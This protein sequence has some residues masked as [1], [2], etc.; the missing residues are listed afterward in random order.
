MPTF[1]LDDEGYTAPRAADFLSTIRDR[2]QAE[3]G[4]TIDWDA[5][6]V[7]GLLTAIMADQLG[8]LGEATQD[9]R[10]SMDPAS[11]RG[12]ALD[13]LAQ[14]VGVTRTPATYS[15]VT[16]A[17]TGVNGT[18]V[19]EGDLVEGGGDD[20]RAR[21]VATENGTISGGTVNIVFQAAEAGPVEATTGAIT[22]IVT[23]R[24]GWTGVTN[25]APATAGQARESDADLRKRRAQSLQTAGSRSAN[26]LRANILDIDDV[27]ACVVLENTSL[28]SV[29]VDAITMDP[30]S[31]GVVVYPSTLTTAQK[32][33]L[34]LAIYAH[35]A[36]GVAMSGSQS[37]TV[38][39]ADDVAHTVKWSYASTSNVTV[40]VEVE[41]ADGFELADVEVPIQ[42]ALTEYLSGLGVGDPARILAGLALI[43]EVEGVDA[44]VLE[45]NGSP[46]D[47]V[48]GTTVLLVLSGSVAVTE[49]P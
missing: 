8:A 25:A 32:E 24:T 37:A 12:L 43:A 22:T 6:V 18:V 34:A 1:G 30:C 21:W 2:Y 26:A 31:V 47:V 28:V 41:L 23:P 29:V 38:T 9:L 27:Q 3:T 19:L 20:G 14:L 44:A 35:V 39:G 36:S 4:L 10:D 15:T 42:E 5:D 48:P 11:A 46:A 49:A 13:N 16:L 45:Y 40:A 33:E 7:L 17:C